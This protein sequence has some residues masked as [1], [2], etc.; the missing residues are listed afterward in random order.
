MEERESNVLSAGA[1]QAVHASEVA[2]DENAA[3]ALACTLKSA[4]LTC[5]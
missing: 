1:T 4:V 3:P 2:A 5:V